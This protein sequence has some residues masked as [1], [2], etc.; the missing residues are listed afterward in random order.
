MDISKLPRMSKTTT[1]PNEAGPDVPVPPEAGFPVI[2]PN[3]PAGDASS[4]PP[5]GL[6][7]TQCHAPNAPGSYYC[8]G[9]GAPLRAGDAPAPQIQ[10][11]VGAEVWVA[12]IVG[13]I[14]MLMGMSFAKWSI[15]RLTGNPH[16]TNVTWQVGEKAG[17]EVDY[18]E[19]EGHV[20]FQDAA[21]FLF[22]L[23]MVLEAI[24]LVVIHSRVRPKL[25]LLALALFITFVATV[26][27]LLVSIK[28]FSAGLLPLLSLLCVGFG[29]YIIAY[30]WR[31]FQ[32]FQRSARAT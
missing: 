32:H 18:W 20:A 28:L 11:G 22:G 26:M 14:V 9:C 30:E 1:P 27:N 16:H 2:Q 31:L 24:V 6:W 8:N 10:P 15:A 5:A 4:P 17:Q 13:I 12:A 3:A 25:P 21:I 19:L 29:G 23:A 7:C